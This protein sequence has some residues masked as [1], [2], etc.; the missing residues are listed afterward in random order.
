MKI[1]LKPRRT[2]GASSINHTSSGVGVG[3]GVTVGEVMGHVVGQVVFEGG[4]SEERE[5]AHITYK[6][7][8]NNIKVCFAHVYIIIMLLYN[9]TAVYLDL[10]CTNT[11][12]FCADSA[13]IR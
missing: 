1:S 9:T 6:L 8:F 10:Y 7:H 5:V 13:C 12:S 2:T 3:V 11:L 4:C